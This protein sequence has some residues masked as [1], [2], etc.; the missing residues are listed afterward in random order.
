[1]QMNRLLLVLSEPLNRFGI[2][3]KYRMPVEKGG[4]P[5]TFRLSCNRLSKYKKTELHT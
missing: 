5:E 3:V 2:S 1:M 4:S